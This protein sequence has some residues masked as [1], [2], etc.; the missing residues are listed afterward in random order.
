SRRRCDDCRLFLVGA[1]AGSLSG[2]QSG[3]AQPARASTWA[4]VVRAVAGRTS[5]RRAMVWWPGCDGG[6]G[7]ES[8]R[9]KAAGQGCRVAPP[10]GVKSSAQGALGFVVIFSPLLLQDV[11]MKFDQSGVDAL[12]EITSRPELVFVRGQG[13]WLED[14]N[15]K[16]YLDFVQ[17]WAVNSLG[18][19]P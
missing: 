13:S 19:C 7:R 14:H 9:P 4:I 8:L 3:A 10:T 11:I 16:R 12:M 5:G 6:P 15:G 2:R 17:G 18:H 1:P